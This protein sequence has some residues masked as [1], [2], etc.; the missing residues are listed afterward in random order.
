MINLKC[1]L[2]GEGGREGWGLPWCRGCRECRGCRGR[3]R[4]GWGWWVWR[5]TQ[6]LWGVLLKSNQELRMHECVTCHTHVICHSYMSRVTLTGCQIFL[7]FARLIVPKVIV[8]SIV[9]IAEAIARNCQKLKFKKCQNCGDVMFL[10][11][12][13]KCLKGHKSL[14]SLCYV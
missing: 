1:F 4:A 5:G 10:I 13:I 2:G 8:L 7:N 6:S 3:W 12:L 11:T 14:G 9:K